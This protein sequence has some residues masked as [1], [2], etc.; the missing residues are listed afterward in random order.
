M[1]V[2]GPVHAAGP[3]TASARLRERGFGSNRPGS[4]WLT[5]LLVL[6]GAVNLVAAEE[7]SAE[8][9]GRNGTSAHAP[10][11]VLRENATLEAAGR[12]AEAARDLDHALEAPDLPPDTRL[13]LEF[14]RERLDRIRH[15]YRLTR[16]ALAAELHTALRDLTEPE[17]ELWLREGRFDSREIDGRRWFFASSL[18]N[19]FFRYPELNARRRR[20]VESD[21]EQHAF[22]ANAVAIR[23]AARRAGQPYVLPKRFEVEMTVTLKENGVPPGQP[24]RAWLPIPRRYPFQDQFRLG[25]SSPPVLAI[26]PLESPIRSA[27][28]EQPAA[29]NAPTVFVLRYAYTAW[30]VSFD[31]APSRAAPV[32]LSDPVLRRFTEPGPHVQFTEPMRSL[33]AT[34][35]GGETNPI[36]RARAFYNWIADHIQYSYAPEY[37]TIDDLGE[38]GRRRRYGDCGIEAFLF[39]TLCRL[40][41]IP[42]RWQSGWHLFPNA[43]TIHDWC[44]IHLPPFGWVPVDPYMGIYAMRYAPSLS[45]AQRL[46]LRDFYFGGLSQY[47]MAANSD[48]QQRL[49]PP[50]RSPRSDNVDFQRGEL[51]ADGRNLYFTHYT[52]RLTWR[53]VPPVR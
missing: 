39:M 20:P 22:W 43:E 10:Q 34:I 53:E 38:F 17:F 41:G 12:F 14:A 27:Y 44:E 8:P 24:V 31:L 47:R 28:L 19:L 23:T 46:E 26:A 21:N 32:D 11:A 4:G 18:S 15:D 29:T 30:G 9:S 48:H 25:D 50:K 7:D 5:A 3:A 40:S 49:D 13:E 33:A 45:R 37:S 36:V 1:R 6:L 51:E 16:E 2:D 52:Y 35:A 42:A